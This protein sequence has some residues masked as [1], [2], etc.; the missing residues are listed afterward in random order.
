MSSIKNV[1]F[2]LRTSESKMLGGKINGQ[3]HLICLWVTGRVS[4][5]TLVAS[6]NYQ[7]L[8]IGNLSD[9]FCAVVS[10]DRFFQLFI[11]YIKARKIQCALVLPPS[12][13]AD[14]PYDPW[15]RRHSRERGMRIIQSE[16]AVVSNVHEAL[17][18]RTCSRYKNLPDSSCCYF[19]VQKPICK[20]CPYSCLIS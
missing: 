20:R 12:S 17:K 19:E 4:Q 18:N 6:P 3:I 2:T 16:K 14:N 1:S 9:S 5:M 11:L 13:A 10:Y 15:A 8:W 7:L